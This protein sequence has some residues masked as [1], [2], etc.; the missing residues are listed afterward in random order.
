MLAFQWQSSASQLLSSPLPSLLI[1]SSHFYFSP[2]QNAFPRFLQRP[3]RRPHQRA[4]SADRNPR[5]IHAWITRPH[6]ICTPHTARPCGTHYDRRKILQRSLGSQE[7]PHWLALLE[8]VDKASPDARP[9][10]HRREY[11]FILSPATT[12]ILIL[13]QY[14]RWPRVS[15]MVS[16][17]G[18]RLRPDLTACTKGMCSP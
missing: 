10:R 17:R 9:P 11:R 16:V 13:D 8:R 18:A 12:F 3:A 2:P 5:R 6:R 7:L 14:F 1:F 15:A 4:R